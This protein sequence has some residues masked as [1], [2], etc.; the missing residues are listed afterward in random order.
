MTLSDLSI[1]NPVFAWMLMA[2]LIIFGGLGFL[3]LGVSQMPD[4]DYPVVNVSVTLEG[5]SPE[6]MESDVAD[7]IEDAVLTVQGIREVSSSSRQGQTSITIEFELS[8]SID[9]AL[10]DVQTKVAQ[11]QRNLPRDIDPPIVT[12]TNPEDQPILWLALSGNR[13]P[14]ELSD[15]VRNEL[16]D[17]FQT[18]AGVGEIQLGGFRQRSVRV[19]L[20]GRKLEAYGLTVGD[21]VAALQRQHVEVPAGRI[22]TAEREMNVRAEGEALRVEDFAGIVI[23]ERG[24]SQ[25]KL[26][27]VAVV[28]DG[29]E[30]KRR[31]SR[32]DGLP[33]QGI[34]IK[35]QRGSNAVEVG[36]AVKVKLA[37]IKK[38]LPADLKLAVSFD[39]TAPVEESIREIEFT[40]VLSVVLT[41][42]V[43]WLFLG[44]WSSTL[45]VL[46]AIPT[47][48]I[49]T[50]AAIYFLGFTLNTFTL[51]ALSLSVG[52]VEI[53]RA[54]V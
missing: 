30:D 8:R 47:S 45:N 26:K 52:I 53:G 15:M 13:T 46:I 29:L 48:I 6:I 12:K 23:A 44:S 36:R 20:D 33:A 2:A 21:V 22:E 27:D 32:A 41:G 38:T 43:C 31:I 4:V 50:F 16:K 10:Q 7:V 11:A 35:K 37:E 17:Q 39:G 9:A 51:L 28:E 14:Q 24:G 49:G 34:G 54:H 42:L 3:R 40:L 25:L 18:V 5:A 19:W 1:K